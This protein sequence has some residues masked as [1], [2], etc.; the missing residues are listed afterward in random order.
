MQ[1]SNIEQHSFMLAACIARKAI[2][3]GREQ[4]LFCEG[5]EDAVKGRL[6]EVEIWFPLCFVCSRSSLWLELHLEL[7]IKFNFQFRIQQLWLELP[8]RDNAARET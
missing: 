4:P 2:D 6:V 7:R 3:G 8:A 1:I 5:A